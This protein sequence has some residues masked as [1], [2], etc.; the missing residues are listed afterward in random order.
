MNKFK[1]IGIGVISSLLTLVVV[2]II[3][4][5]CG[6]N[7]TSTEAIG[8]GNVINSESDKMSNKV[9]GKWEIIGSGAIDTNNKS[10]A[11]FINLYTTLFPKESEIE[12]KKDKIILHGQTINYRVEDKKIMMDNNGKNEICIEPYFNDK[13]YLIFKIGNF[14][15]VMENLDAYKA[16][17]NKADANL[18]N[19]DLESGGEAKESISNSKTVNESEESKSNSTNSVLDNNVKFT[20][21]DYSINGS[22]VTVHLNVVSNYDGEVNLWQDG[23]YLMNSNGTK[24]SLDIHKHLSKGEN[25]F[26]VV[27]GENKTF[28]LYFNNY[29]GSDELNLHVE[30][31]WCMDPALSM[32]E[33]VTM[34]LS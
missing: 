22:E 30:K 23:M 34:K 10:E 31:I 3:F 25:K 11:L 1:V 15:A 12:I 18:N 24:F 14:G 16:E 5:Y 21:Q 4:M 13:G 29:K 28:E 32:K 20:V 19:K 6:S 7:K 26:S 2:G 33:K 9:I 8:Q 27:K 17:K